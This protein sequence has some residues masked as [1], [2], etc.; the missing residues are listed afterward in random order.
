MDILA[1]NQTTTRK[2]TLELQESNDKW[3][4]LRQGIRDKIAKTATTQAKLMLS[5]QDDIGNP[6]QLCAVLS[7]LRLEYTEIIV[8]EK[9]E[10]AKIMKEYMDNI[11]GNMGKPPLS[12]DDAIKL[13]VY[14]K[15]IQTPLQNWDVPHTGVIW[16]KRGWCFCHH[17]QSGNGTTWLDN[18]QHTINTKIAEEKA[19]S[20]LS[21][22]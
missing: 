13:K 18:I 19:L 11:M 12:N 9:E 16:P 5:E 21:N 20:M 17:N 2:F 3:T 6:A 10:Q 14:D 22:K 8:Q 4:A 7:T 1:S 15:Y